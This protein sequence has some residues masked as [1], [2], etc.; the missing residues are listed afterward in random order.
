MANVLI[1]QNPHCLKSWNFMVKYARIRVFSGPYFR[2]KYRIEDS[3]LIRENTKTRAGENP[4][5]GV[6][7]AV[8]VNRLH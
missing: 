2:Y 8:P 4:S 1:I 7:F 3:V 5:S 6:F